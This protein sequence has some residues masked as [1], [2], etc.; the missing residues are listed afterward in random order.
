MTEATFGHDLCVIGGCGH[1]GLPLA[2]ICA[3]S[4]LSTVIYD[5]DRRKVELVRSGTMPFPEEGAEEMLE[6]VLRCGQ[7]QI[8]DRPDLLS[9][10]RFLVMIIGTPVDEHLNPSSVAIDRALGKCRERRSGPA[11]FALW[12]PR[13]TYL[14]TNR[15]HA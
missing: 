6:R 10:C 7:L 1:V 12:Y 3:D 4:G 14:P 5:V 15:T 8:E 13:A 11:L 2:L 9:Q